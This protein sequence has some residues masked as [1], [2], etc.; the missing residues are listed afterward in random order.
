MSGRYLTDVNLMLSGTA[1]DRSRHSRNICSRRGPRLPEQSTSH[2]RL[3]ED[4]R[5]LR[6]CRQTA[7]A[8]IR[9]RFEW[10][11]PG[12][13]PRTSGGRRLTETKLFWRYRADIQIA[14]ALAAISSTWKHRR[15]NISPAG[16]EGVLSYL[17]L[18]QT[19][20][21]K[22]EF[23][24]VNCSVLTALSRRRGHTLSEASSVDPSFPPEHEVAGVSKVQTQDTYP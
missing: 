11:E 3:G 13:R 22:Y 12:I 18:S 17:I 2:H 6:Q 14:R 16:S 5:V 8:L 20:G 21:A 7:V 23:E 24:S 4:S 1:R 19:V 10:R 9:S 15:L